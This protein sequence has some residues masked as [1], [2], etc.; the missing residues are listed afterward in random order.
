MQRTTNEKG[1]TNYSDEN[2]DEEK[3]EEKKTQTIFSLQ[4]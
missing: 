4:M 2:D 1:K 3:G